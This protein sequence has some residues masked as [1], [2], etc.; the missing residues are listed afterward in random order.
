[1]KSLVKNW[2]SQRACKELV[3]SEGRGSDHDKSIDETGQLRVE[4][5]LRL[6]C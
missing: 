5:E 4:Q 2:L 3:D 1:V 6:R